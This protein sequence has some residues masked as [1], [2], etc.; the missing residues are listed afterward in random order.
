MSHITFVPST[1]RLDAL[2]ATVIL[3]DRRPF[4]EKKGTRLDQYAHSPVLDDIKQEV[5]RMGWK[6]N[7]QSQSLWHSF[8]YLAA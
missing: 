3:D 8:T 5:I 2:A 1:P 7:F 4:I 6:W